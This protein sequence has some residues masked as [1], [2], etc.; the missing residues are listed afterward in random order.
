MNAE[1]SGEVV[2]IGQALLEKGGGREVVESR[3]RWKG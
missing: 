3:G 2:K 1:N